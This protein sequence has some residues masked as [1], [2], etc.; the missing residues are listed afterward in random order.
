MT[1]RCMDKDP[2][3]TR[4]GGSVTE[5]HRYDPYGRAT[6]MDADWSDDAD[7]L[8]DTYNHFQ[9]QG[10]WVSSTTGLH[11]VRYR[12]GHPT[13]GRWMQRDPAGYFDSMSL[14]ESI[15]SQPHMLLDSDGQVVH[16]TSLFA[17]LEIG[18]KNWE[19]YRN[20][21]RDLL[22]R[23]A[24][25]IEAAFDNPAGRSAAAR[26]MSAV[27]DNM[28]AGGK[29]A[30]YPLASDLLEHWRDGSGAEYVFTSTN[31]EEIVSHEVFQKKYWT[32]ADAYLGGA[33]A[34]SARG[35]V[36][37]VWFP[38]NSTDFGYALGEFGVSFTGV[39]CRRNTNEIVAT[40]SFMVLDDYRFRASEHRKVLGVTLKGSW[41]L[42]LE[43]YYGARVFEITS[44]RWDG[45]LVIRRR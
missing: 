42:L 30:G 1:K 15:R 37:K 16:P 25:F 24:E 32:I 21:P 3:N 28:I 26:M 23:Q 43:E 8:P 17:A 41:F 31:V 29:F 12:I 5:R 33:P 19:A 10:T 4:V 7:G 2:D 39:F 22:R 14:L 20:M 13:F 6:V 40:G 38:L 34:K 36:R 35:Q 27:V 45:E 18:I 9:H 11:T 44:Q